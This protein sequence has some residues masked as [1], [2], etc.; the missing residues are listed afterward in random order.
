MFFAGEVI[1]EGL[2]I[3][4]FARHEVIGFITEKDSIKGAVHWSPLNAPLTD[5]VKSSAPHG[6]LGAHVPDIVNAYIPLVA[7]ALVGMG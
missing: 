6:V 4:G 2:N 1:L 7:I 5:V 3:S